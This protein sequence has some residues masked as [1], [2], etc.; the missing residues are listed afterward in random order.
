LIEIN[1]NPSIFQSTEVLKEVIGKVVSKT[2]D[3]VL[4]ISDTRDKGEKVR[5]EELD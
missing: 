2:L 3:N 4:K 1:T 5:V